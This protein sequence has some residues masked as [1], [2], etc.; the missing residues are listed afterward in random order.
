MK[1]L[2]RWRWFIVVLVIV[3]AGVPFILFSPLAW[4][5]GRIE[6]RVQQ[7]PLRLVVGK[8]RLALAGSL[9]MW[10]G[11]TITITSLVAGMP[12][13]PPWGG[14]VAA[15]AGVGLQA[16]WTL[17]EIG[18]LSGRITAGA[19]RKGLARI[20]RKERRAFWVK[21]TMPG[22]WIVLR[23]TIPD[24]YEFSRKSQPVPLH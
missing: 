11:V 3:T 10:A 19:S 12:V 18:I 17:G 20:Y 24:I 8:G 7:T 23:L 2:R 14:V 9:L 4:M 22:R 16:I 13:D 15:L 6:G 1:S 21:I 5:F